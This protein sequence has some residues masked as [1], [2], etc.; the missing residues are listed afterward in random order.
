MA[1]EIIGDYR[2][3]DKIDPPTPPLMYGEQ[4][5]TLIFLGSNA[6]LL[7]APRVYQFVRS[8]RSCEEFLFHIQ[9]RGEE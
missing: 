6:K 3:L 7:V 1:G 9:Y 5:D 2:K 4:E 8:L